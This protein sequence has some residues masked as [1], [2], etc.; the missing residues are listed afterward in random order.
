MRSPIRSSLLYA[1]IAVPLI[2]GAGQTN[3]QNTQAGFNYPHAVKKLC[4]VSETEFNES[5]ASITFPKATGWAK[6]FFVADLLSDRKFGPVYDE[7]SGMVYVFPSDGPAFTDRGGNPDCDFF[8]WST[9]MFYWLT[10]PVTAVG[11]F[12]TDPVPPTSKTDFVFASEFFYTLDGTSLKS[13]KGPLRT[14]GV[15]TEKNDDIVTSIEQAGGNGVLFYNPPKSLPKGD[16]PLVYYSVHTN[17]PYGYQRAADLA[18]ASYVPDNFVQSSAEICNTIAFAFLNGYANIADPIATGLYA[19]YCLGDGSDVASQTKALK[20]QFLNKEIDHTSVAEQTVT[21]EKVETAVDYLAMSMELKMSWVESESLDKPESYIQQEATIPTF[22]AGSSGT[23]TLV[24]SGT[25]TT[26]LALVGMH[27]VGSVKGHPEMIWATF[28]HANNTPN[29]NYVYQDVENDV[30]LTTDIGFGTWLFSDSTSTAANAEYAIGKTDRGNLEI[31]SSPSARSADLTKASNVNRLSPWGT[32]IE[33]A[34]DKMEITGAAESNSEVI[35]A[36][37]AAIGVLNGFYKQNMQAPS[38]PRVNYILTGASWGHT[39]KPGQLDLKKFPDGT[40]PNT[41][42]GTAAM[43]STTM[44]TFTQTFNGRINENGCFGCHGL[45]GETNA[46]D[47]SHIFK[48][49]KSIEK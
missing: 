1:L 16:N 4:A 19:L 44:E 24:Q 7:T 31:V 38:D 12:P 25:K 40:D 2:F 20:D 46:F 14:T 43:A 29:T 49:I 21:V 17:R 42:V 22:T 10:S 13:Q 3:A 15:R 26:T 11:E 18:D 33:N 36:N 34:Y 37:L 47:V 27:V 8:N 35:S 9:Q 41:I 30:R 39:Q 6:L 45:F 5:W 23:P 28:E 32:H 48:K